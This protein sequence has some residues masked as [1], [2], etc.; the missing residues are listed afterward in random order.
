MIYVSAISGWAKIWQMNFNVDKCI[1]LRF[2]R[3][4]SPIINDYF[5]N[6]QVIQFKDV[7]KYLGI[8]LDNTL[9]WNT[10]II[11]IIKYGST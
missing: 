5:L 1:L 9:S 4:H 2:T 7:Y 8:Q 10:H 11:T 6:N 3:S